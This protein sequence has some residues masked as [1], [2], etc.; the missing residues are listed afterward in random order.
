MY[1]I[2]KIS[3]WST[4]VMCI[5]IV[6]IQS[7]SPKGDTCE[8]LWVIHVGRF[9]VNTKGVTCC[10]I[11]PWVDCLR[12]AVFRAGKHSFHR[13]RAWFTRAD[14][15]AL[16]H[17]S[18]APQA[19]RQRGELQPTVSLGWG[20]VMLWCGLVSFMMWPSNLPVSAFSFF[21][22][23]HSGDRTCMVCEYHRVESS[24]ARAVPLSA[25]NFTIVVLVVWALYP[26]LWR[27][28]P[29]LYPWI[30]NWTR[31]YG[32]LHIPY[33]TRKTKKTSLWIPSYSH[34]KSPCLFRKNH[35]Y[36]H[37]YS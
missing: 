36:K 8:G 29:E 37:Y 17:L 15:N 21:M 12:R 4:V 28:L 13:V 34:E 11:E 16:S 7:S 20:I 23:S 18:P 35:H 19:M 6:G 5:C 10:W 33:D 32:L 2:L 22:F 25:S 26:N 1:W 14:A 3:H 31:K 30:I 24:I 27:L 9:W